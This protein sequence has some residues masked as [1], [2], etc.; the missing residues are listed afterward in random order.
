[1]NDLR[2]VNTAAT[3]QIEAASGT[4]LHLQRLSTEDGPGIR[5]TVFF[6]G[7]PL[8]CAWCHNPESISLKPQVQWLENRCIGCLTCVKACPNGA[9]S[10]GEDGLHIDRQHCQAC[11]T[12]A[13]ACPGN[14]LELLGKQV[15]AEELS[16]ELLKDVAYFETSQGGV[17][18][19]GGE[20]TLQPHFALEILRRMKQAGL[21][22]ALDTCGLCAR[23][24]LESLLE[25]SDVILYDIKLM[26][27]QLHRH[28]TGQDNALILANL[29]WLAETMGSEKMLWIRTPLIPGATATQDNVRAIGRFIADELGDKVARWELCAFN[30]LCRDKYRR[31]DMAWDFAAT[32]L[33]TRRELD[34]VETWARTSGVDPARTF[35]TGAARVED[36]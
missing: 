32:P 36:N 10:R 18:L 2:E 26:D 3:E 1:M 4:I 35:V 24:T 16:A 27:S 7:C 23:A 25:W 12:C 13:E 19:S 8:H 9:L 31:L 5:T 17:T 29:R 34:E 14:A 15:T 6:K 33:M 21:P 22:T 11:G 28:F 20:P 30:N